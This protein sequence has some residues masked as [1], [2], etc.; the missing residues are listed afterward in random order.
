[1]KLDILAFGAHP[2]DVELSCGGILL[3]HIADGKK[4]G[5]CELTRGEMGTRGTP[6][7][8]IREANNSA[9]ILGISM[10]ENLHLDDVFFVNDKES[11]L[12]V[13]KIIRRYRPE[14]IICNAITD[15]HPDHGRGAKLVS[16][17]AF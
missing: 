9:K 2:D 12:A 8:R 10:R 15:R 13:A 17:A 16:D 4:V 3:R 6:E 7:I 14:I 5:I 1:M 11:Q